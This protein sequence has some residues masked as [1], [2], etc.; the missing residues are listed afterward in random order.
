MVYEHIVRRAHVAFWA[1]LI[2]SLRSLSSQ[3]LPSHPHERPAHPGCR[4]ASLARSIAPYALVVSRGRSK[5][6]W[7]TLK[8]LVP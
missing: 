2:P 7:S 6:P 8:L 5:L 3:R 4:I 1:V